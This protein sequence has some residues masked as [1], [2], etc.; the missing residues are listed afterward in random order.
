MIP[1][2]RYICLPCCDDRS[3]CTNRKEEGFISGILEG[4]R[5]IRRELKDACH[6]WKVANYKVVNRCTLLGLTEESDFSA[7]ETAMG[8]DP[9]HLTDAALGIVAGQLCEM[10]EGNNAMFSGAGREPWRTRR[11]DRRRLSR[12]GTRGSTDPARDEAAVKDE[13]VPGAVSPLVATEPGA[14]AAVALAMVATTTAAMGSKK[15]N[16]CLND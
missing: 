10:A 15:V 1:L 6:D 4:L 11:T 5:E 3:H 7:W 14:T 8:S 13:A 2:P 9:V 16:F 12:E